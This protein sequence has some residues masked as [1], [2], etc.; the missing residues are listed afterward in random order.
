M[1]KLIRVLAK[2]IALLL[3]ALVLTLGSLAYHR[4]YIPRPCPQ[5]VPFDYGPCNVVLPRGGFPLSY[6]YD[7]QD[8]SVQGTLGPEDDFRLVPFLIN[9][10]LYAGGMLAMRWL[11]Q[12]RREPKSGSKA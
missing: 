12:R 11:W 9:I 10:L 3:A 2:S 1:M 7:K 5:V 6:V 8:I 4:S